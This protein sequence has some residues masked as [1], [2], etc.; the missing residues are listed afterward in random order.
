MPNP[1]PTR[2][3]PAG[4]CVPVEYVRC[5]DAD[6][7]VVRFA[8]SDREWA[9]RLLDCW[10]E[11]QNTAEGQQATLFATSILEEVEELHLQ[12]PIRGDAVNVLRGMLS[13]DRLLG[14]LW[15]A[16]DRTL[17]QALVEAGHATQTKG[18]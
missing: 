13:F 17:S 5:R 1:W 3:P 12:V 6:T 15:I 4:I 11:E 16:T 7:P 14:H 18:G 8:R 10:A 2:R 9:V